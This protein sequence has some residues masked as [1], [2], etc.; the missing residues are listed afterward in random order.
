MNKNFVPKYHKFL[1]KIPK[2]LRMIISRLAN[3][4]LIVYNHQQT[5]KKIKENTTDGNTI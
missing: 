1:E 2:S 3:N 5:N 4:P